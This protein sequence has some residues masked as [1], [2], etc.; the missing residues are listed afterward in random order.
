MIMIISMIIIT[1]LYTADTEID[2]D[3]FVYSIVGRIVAYEAVLS[4]FCINVY[5]FSLHKIIEIL[6]L[7]THFIFIDNVMFNYVNINE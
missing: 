7:S 1:M 2:V 6:S 4:K 5:F 3:I